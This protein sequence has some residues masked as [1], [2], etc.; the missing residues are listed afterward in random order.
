ME[1]TGESAHDHV[2]VLEVSRVRGMVAPATASGA[3][4]L[5]CAVIHY[6][7]FAR[8]ILCRFGRDAAS[9]CLCGKLFGDD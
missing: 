5:H 4:A 9:S 1:I 6:M 3:S 7:I 8:M 2:E